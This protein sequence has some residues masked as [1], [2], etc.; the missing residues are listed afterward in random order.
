MIYLAV[1]T[2]FLVGNNVPILGAVVLLLL[3]LVHIIFMKYNY[4]Y[5]V[6]IKKS[7]A[8]NMEIKELLRISAKDISH[9]HRNMNGRGLTIEMLNNIKYTVEENFIVFDE[10]NKKKIKPITCVKMRE[11]R[12]ANLDNRGLMARAA[13][14]KLVIQ[15]LIKIQAFKA[16]EKM[17]RVYKSKTKL[18]RI[19]KSD[20]LNDTA[21][22]S[23]ESSY[24]NEIDHDDKDDNQSRRGGEATNTKNGLR[25]RRSHNKSI[26]DDVSQKSRQ[27]V[28]KSP[29]VLPSMFGD[30]DMTS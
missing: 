27:S 2:G 17:K 11:E 18:S 15:L 8:R 30:D 29:R 7:V 24:F 25:S 28:N 20:N 6:A 16:S 4:V 23:D 26:G 1:L 13:F 12:F 19:I 22:D 10:N 5:E 14:K 9:F 3:Y 21:R